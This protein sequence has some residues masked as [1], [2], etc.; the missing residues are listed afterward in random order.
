MSA[1]LLDT[2][3]VIAA[4]GAPKID[5]PEEAAI[6]VITLGELRAG[7]ALAG[8]VE[9]RTARQARLKAVREAFEPLAVDEQVADQFGELLAAARF[10]GRSEK[11]SDLLIAATAAT[12]GRTLYTLD[13]RQASFAREAGLAVVA[14]A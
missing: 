10:G 3:V 1:A 2:S 5:L 13:A 11:A 4:N 9:I 8:S 7:V 6:S 14:P 12:T